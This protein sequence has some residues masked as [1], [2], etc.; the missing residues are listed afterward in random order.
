MA[1]GIIGTLLGMALVGAPDITQEN[2]IAQAVALA[3]GYGEVM[4]LIAFVT[5]VA[6]VMSMIDG[7]FL[8]TAFTFVVDILH[9]RETLDSLEADPDK[10]DRLLLRVRIALIGIAVTAIWGVKLLLEWLGVGLFDFLYVV[11]ITQLALCG[12]VFI[13]LTSRREARCPLWL[14]IC[15]ALAVGFGSVFVGTKLDFRWIADGAGTFTIFASCLAAFWAT[16]PKN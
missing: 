1:P 6:C 15:L 14:P 11:I 12:P 7:L 10:A 2:I 5:I 16:K 13:A 8:A 9:P 4:L 3:P